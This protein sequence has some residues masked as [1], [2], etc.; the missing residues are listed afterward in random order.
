M[1][2]PHLF[3][4]LVL[5]LPTAYSAAAETHQKLYVLSSAG[6]DVT[7]IDV[8]S[9]S[10]I[11]SIEVGDRPHGIAAPR[12]QDILYIAT[13]FDNGLTV[14]DPVK[15]VVIKK[16]KIFGNRPNEIDVTSDGRFVYLPILG[17]GVYEVF[18]TVEEK[19][20]ARIA[21][22]GF[23]HNV[24]ISPDDRYAYLSPMDRGRA[25]AEAVAQGSFPTTLNEK[26]YVVDVSSHT[27][28]ATIPTG[29]APRPIA[30]SPDGKR[31]YVNTDGLQG[32]LVLDLDRREQVARVEYQLTDREKASPSRSHGM[33]ATPDGTE[34]WVSDVNHGLLF[35]FDVTQ[36]PPRQVARLENG[37]PVYWLTVTPDGKTVYVSSAPGDVVT[38]F[39]V[40]TRSKKATIQLQKGKNPK[41]LLVLNVPVGD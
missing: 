26:I 36:D 8:A 40:K 32:F 19:I 29:D 38:A 17:H 22:N 16:H 4:T 11:G 21:T 3:I 25:P 39:D 31:L 2:L 23:P 41:R 1:K 9:N 5:L 13:E 33:I 14:I 34:L 6:N 20:V 7:V 35:V 28:A 10:I 24:V 18:D 15:D 37:A 30:I 12:S 27:V